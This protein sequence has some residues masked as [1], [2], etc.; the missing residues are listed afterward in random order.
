MSFT[1]KRRT[2]TNEKFIFVCDS[3]IASRN[4][5]EERIWGSAKD[6]CDRVTVCV[7]VCRVHSNEPNED[8]DL[9]D[10]HYTSP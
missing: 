9:V 10:F 3:Q 6:A 4:R 7:C 2:N 5:I 8:S 1:L